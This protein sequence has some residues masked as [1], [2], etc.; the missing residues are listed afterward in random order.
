MVLPFFLMYVSIL[1]RD[2]NFL[3]GQQ[4]SLLVLTTLLFVT[5]FLPL[6]S[7]HTAMKRAK[8]NELE[9]ISEHFREVNTK[10][11]EDLRDKNYG[12]DL[13]A[14]VESLEKLDFMYEKVNSMPVWPFNVRNIG[15][16]ISA[17]MI[18]IIIFVMQHY[19]AKYL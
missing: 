1:F 13:V 18:P 7:V 11:K 5:F 17:T 3:I 19:L 2:T 9:S 12:D 6:G 14:D 16:L 8:E 10:V 15:R 4:L